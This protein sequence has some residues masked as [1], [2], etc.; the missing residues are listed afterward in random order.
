MDKM[1]NTLANSLF[2]NFHNLNR[3]VRHTMF[4]IGSYDFEG[5]T[6]NY[7]EVFDYDNNEYIVLG[8]FTLPKENKITLKV[9]NISTN[10]VKSLASWN[11]DNLHTYI[12]IINTINEIEFPDED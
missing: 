9:K 1:F 2:S 4:S 10:E 12:N 5:K 11:Y 6:E 3:D 8:F 7:P